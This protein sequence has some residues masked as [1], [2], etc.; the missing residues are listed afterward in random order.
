MLGRLNDPDKS[1]TA[2]SDC[3]VGVAS[4]NIT[5]VGHLVRNADAG[6]PQHDCT[7]RAEILA[8]IW[9]FG[10]AG[11]SESTRGREI[12]L[13]EKFV[14]EAGSAADDEGHASLGLLQGKVVAGH[15]ETL[16][17]NVVGVLL[18]LLTPRNGEGMVRP[19]TDRRHVQIC[20]LTG[21]EA[22]WTGHLDG[23][24]EGITWEYF[25][26]S[27]RAAVSNVVN[28]KT[29]KAQEALSSPD[30]DN[31]IEHQLLG[32]LLQVNPNRAEGE[33]GTNDVAVQE[34]LVE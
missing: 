24:A 33:R 26:I 9:T 28:N 22:P 29:S 16:L 12:R 19:E 15:G 8:T 11:C 17:V 18:L 31:A 4:N 2:C 34:D 20:V 23:D 27:R 6:R 25:D 7:V 13:T 30:S 3:A 21:A 32:A 5:D 1:E 14:R 10:E